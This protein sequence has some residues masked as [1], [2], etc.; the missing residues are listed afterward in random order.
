MPRRRSLAH[1]VGRLMIRLGV[2]AIAVTVA[3]GSLLAARRQHRPTQATLVGSGGS[4]TC[5][6]HLREAVWLRRFP[7]RIF[8]KRSGSG[9][10]RTGFSGSGLAPAFPSRH[11]PEA[12]R[13]PR[14][15]SRHTSIRRF[16]CTRVLNRCRFPPTSS[17]PSN[18]DR[19]LASHLRRVFCISIV[20]GQVRIKI[21]RVELAQVFQHRPSES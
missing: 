17:D 7:D 4:H 9:V 18:Q 13:L 3:G 8:G 21:A 5:C 2:W 12:L 10:S 19:P 15:L 16:F 20:D 11:L 6:G 1:L 14:F